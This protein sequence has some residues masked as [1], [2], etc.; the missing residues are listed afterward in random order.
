M[1]ERIMA[2]SYVSVRDMDTQRCSLSLPKDYV[3][4]QSHLTLYLRSI[5][6]QIH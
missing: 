6:T 3:V 5:R 1:K 4:H 2:Y